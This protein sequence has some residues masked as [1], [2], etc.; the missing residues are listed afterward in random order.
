MSKK[1]TFV[2]GQKYDKGCFD[3]FIHLKGYEHGTAGSGTK[4]NNFQGIINIGKAE[5]NFK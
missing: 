1:F 2:K 3:P 5:Y 4:S